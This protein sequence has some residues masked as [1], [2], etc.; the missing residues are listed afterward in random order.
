MLE[1]RDK[2]IDVMCN[3]TF[4][5]PVARIEERCS[6]LCDGPSPA[7]ECGELCPGIITYM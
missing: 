5:D 7:R 3:H 6:I 4:I 1:Q 2:T